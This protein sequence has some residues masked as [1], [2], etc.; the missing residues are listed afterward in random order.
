MPWSRHRWRE[1]SNT[2]LKA[3]I[4]SLVLSLHKVQVE[5]GKRLW[6][7][8]KHCLLGAKQ[9]VFS[10]VIPPGFNLKAPWISFNAPL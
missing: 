5:I 6:L 2:K 8:E 3:M 1:N 7:R 9:S 10:S 4:F